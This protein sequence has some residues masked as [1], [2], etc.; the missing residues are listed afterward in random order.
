M[1]YKVTLDPF[2]MGLSVEW[3]AED[4]VSLISRHSKKLT[5]DFIIDID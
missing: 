4:L 5:V 1:V 2:D 3:S